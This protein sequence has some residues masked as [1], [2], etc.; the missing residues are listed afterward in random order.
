MSR[1][2]VSP[3][4]KYTVLRLSVFVLALVVLT[5]AGARSWLALGLAAVIS[6][7]LSLVLLRRQREEMAADIQRR[8]EARTSAP[9]PSRFGKAYDADNDAEDAEVRGD[10]TH[11]DGTQ[12]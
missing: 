6:V 11:R 3:Y 10:G 4:L 1:Q 12:R 9:R 2:G 8:I 5:W 7:L